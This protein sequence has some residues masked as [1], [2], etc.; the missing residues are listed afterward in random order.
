MR[1]TPSEPMITAYSVNRPLPEHTPRARCAGAYPTNVRASAA[2]MN[3]LPSKYELARNGLTSAV[4]ST[5]IP[6]MI[7]PSHTTLRTTGCEPCAS[8]RRCEIARPSSCSSGRK[9]PGAERERHEPERRQR[10][11]LVGPTDRLRTDAEERIGGKTGQQQ[12]DPDRN[13]AFGQ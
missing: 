6:T 5:A 13:R 10:S 9:S 2:T 12:S 7:P 3:Q 11:E 4:Q 8:A 1:T